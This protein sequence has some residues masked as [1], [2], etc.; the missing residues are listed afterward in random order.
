MKIAPGVYEIGALTRGYFKAG[1]TK[2]FIVEY[3]EGLVIIDTFYDGD[4]QLFLDEIAR[5]GKTPQDIKHIA[6]THAHRGHLGGMAALKRLSGAPIYAHEWEADI[7]AGNRPIHNPHLFAFDPI[8]AWPII[9]FG[10][11]TARW[12]PFDPM[13][14]DQLVDEGSKI[15][16]LQ[17]LHTP[18]H[19]P[20]H[21]AFYWPERQVLFTGDAFVTWPLITPGW[22]ST[23]LNKPQSW[24]TLERMSALDVEVIGPGHGS[25]ITK[26]GSAVLKA[27]LR[28][29][30][31]ST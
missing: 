12:N 30:P 28:E 1:Y 29:R 31:A 24:D 15:G 27:L 8:Q 21:L 22:H 26:G 23:M 5:M 7:I 20:G 2:A 10:Q 18:G 11:L 14:V 13:P 3:E 17:V 9:F 16:P 25:S 4:A 19:T 6:L